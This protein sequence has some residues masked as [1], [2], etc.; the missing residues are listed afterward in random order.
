MLG[1]RAFNQK[2]IK[3]LIGNLIRVK[4]E[5][6]EPQIESEAK[7]VLNLHLLIREMS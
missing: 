4:F 2:M 3:E 6:Y 7:R 1:T 5:F